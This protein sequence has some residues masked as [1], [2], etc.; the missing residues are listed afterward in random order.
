MNT[1]VKKLADI[2]ATAEA[3]VEHAQA[4]KSEIS[5]TGNLRTRLR[6]S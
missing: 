1:V 6:S 3:I 2:E 4:Q 5:S